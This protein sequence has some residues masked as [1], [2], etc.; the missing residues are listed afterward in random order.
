MRKS[1]LQ[2]Y[3]S[4]VSLA[5]LYPEPR[6]PLIIEPFAGGAGY[7]LRHHEGRQIWLNDLNDQVSDV[8]QYLVDA[9][10]ERI[11]ALPASPEDP[12]LTQ[13]ERWLIGWRVGICNTYPRRRPSPWATTD[14][15]AESRWG[16]GVRD[17]LADCVP[18]MRDWHVTGLDY[19]DLPDVEAT[20][21]IDPPYQGKYGERYRH[22]SKKIDYRELA[23]WCRSRRG[24]VIVCEA[25]GA[26]WL[27]FQPLA[28][29]KPRR[30]VKQS[31]VHYC[32]AEVMW[33]HDLD[34]KCNEP[35]SEM[36]T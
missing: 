24:Q 15:R 33:T 1:I 36:F 2:Y 10:P 14:K 4:K 19:R 18:Q 23:E 3:G 34:F 35:L 9:D 20:W 25:S 31:E 17:Y 5:P 12:G 22:G 26:D 30:S 11:R 28:G 27:P 8:W 21:F 16:Q 32:A 13:S 7:S 29:W 6:Y